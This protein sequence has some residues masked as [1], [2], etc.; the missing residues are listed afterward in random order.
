M[1]EFVIRERTAVNQ[2]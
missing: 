2:T 1:D